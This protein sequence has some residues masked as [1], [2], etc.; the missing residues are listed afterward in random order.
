LFDEIE[1]A[2]HDVFNV[3][4]QI[5][6]DGRLTDGQGRI[7][8]FKNTVIIMTSNVGSQHYQ[9]DVGD[10]DKLV[11]EELRR[12]F[13]PEFL[14][15]VDEIVVFHKLGIEQIKQIVKIQLSHVIKR[16][17]DQRIAL[18]V[19]EPVKALLAKEGYDPVFG[20]RPL[21]RVIQRKLLD[22]L[23]MQVLAGQFKEGDKVKVDVDK[24]PDTLSFSKS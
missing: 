6:D 2:H 22:A 7:V 21:K 3:L 5:L 19:S 17:A 23:S 1:K 15:R 18:T 10:V 4:L 16:L 14:N 24:K 12:Q 11:R 8:D 20:A 9:E 13:R